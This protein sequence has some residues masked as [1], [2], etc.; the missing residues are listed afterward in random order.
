MHEDF[1]H[2]SFCKSLS[3]VEECD[4]NK[5]HCIWWSVVL[6]LNFDSQRWHEKSLVLWWRNA[7]N[8]GTGA[9]SHVHGSSRMYCGPPLAQMYRATFVKKMKFWLWG[10]TASRLVASTQNREVSI[11]KNHFWVC[12][13]QLYGRTCCSLWVIGLWLSRGGTFLDLT[14]GLVFLYLENQGTSA[15]AGVH[16]TFVSYRGRGFWRLWSRLVQNCGR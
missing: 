13:Y 7:Q 1:T 5:C 15:L 2:L 12:W 8:T 16:N 11:E 6:I 4:M 9:K 3:S 10:H 14:S